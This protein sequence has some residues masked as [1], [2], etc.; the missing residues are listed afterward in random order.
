MDVCERPSRTW[1]WA[2]IFIDWYGDGRDGA[3]DAD[4]RNAAVDNTTI[5]DAGVNRARVSHL[6]CDPWHG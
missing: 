1:A 2:S 3:D 5:D 6:A 4:H